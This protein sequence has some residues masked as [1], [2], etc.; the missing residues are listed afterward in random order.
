MEENKW[1]DAEAYHDELDLQVPCRGE[2]QRIVLGRWVMTYLLFNYLKVVWGEPL[3][4]PGIMPN[5]SESDVGP[6]AGLSTKGLA[7]RSLHDAPVSPWSPV[8]SP[9]PREFSKMSEESIEAM[10]V[11]D[12]NKENRGLSLNPG[13]DHELASSR[14][15]VRASPIG[16]P[17][18]AEVRFNI[19]PR[20]VYASSNP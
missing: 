17:P 15:V 8:V 3:N 12:G 4:E 9:L 19:S 2:D 14:F 1:F 16:T 5:I 20:C 10:H 13:K 11:G 7:P 6:S 18:P